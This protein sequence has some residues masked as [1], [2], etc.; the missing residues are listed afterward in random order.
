MCYKKYFNNK[1]LKKKDVHRINTGNNT[2]NVKYYV[3]FLYTNI[4]LLFFL[5]LTRF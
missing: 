3:N 5:G 1:K 2:Y 4:I